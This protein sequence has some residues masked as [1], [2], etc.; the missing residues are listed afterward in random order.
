MGLDVKRAARLG[1]GC[2]HEVWGRGQSLVAEIMLHLHVHEILQH[3]K[4][5]GH[6]DVLQT[7]S[8]MPGRVAASHKHDYTR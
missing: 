4:G 8:P 6:P 2:E 5:S 7:V 1:L 3:E